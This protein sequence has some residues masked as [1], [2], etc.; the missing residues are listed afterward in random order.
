MRGL[1]RQASS[2]FPWAIIG[3]IIGPKVHPADICR[4]SLRLT[5]A[6]WRFPRRGHSPEASVRHLNE[7]YHLNDKFHTTYHLL[8][9]ISPPTMA[10]SYGEVEERIQDAVQFYHTLETPNIV[11]IERE[12]TV[13]VQRLQARIAGRLSRF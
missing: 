1:N 3:C 12:F 4:E 5:R 8:H 2:S 13:P 6:Q 7:N 10:E 9:V 11:K